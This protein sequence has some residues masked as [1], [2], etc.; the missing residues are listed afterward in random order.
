MI[1]H[2]R[3]LDANSKISKMAR[4]SFQN[5]H[6]SFNLTLFILIKLISLKQEVSFNSFILLFLWRLIHSIPI[7]AF[8]EN[9]ENT[10]PWEVYR[11][12]PCCGLKRFFRTRVNQITMFNTV[13][14][15]K[16]SQFHT[17]PEKWTSGIKLFIKWGL[18]L[19]YILPRDFH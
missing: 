4:S 9:K 13:S 16:Y 18:S 7:I 15:G 14:L 10:L 3:E 5:L 19:C 1:N 2:T 12:Q 11:F 17:T 6:K 8:E